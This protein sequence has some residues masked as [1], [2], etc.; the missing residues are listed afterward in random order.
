MHFWC[1]CWGRGMH[2]TSPSVYGC[3]GLTQTVYVCASWVWVYL[4]FEVRI[5]G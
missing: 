3:Q 5:T 2:V 4:E 1:V